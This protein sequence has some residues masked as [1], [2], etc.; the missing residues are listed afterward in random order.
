MKPT[1]DHPRM[2]DESLLRHDPSDA[3]IEC[4]AL[5]QAKTRQDQSH[6]ALETWIA[7]AIAEL[8]AER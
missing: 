8:A 5:Q 4:D 3:G 2:A 7:A 1:D 6:A